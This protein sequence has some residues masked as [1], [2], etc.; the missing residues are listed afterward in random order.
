MAIQDVTHF[1]AVD[2][3]ADPAFFLNFLEEVNKLPCTAAWK[4]VILD[5]LRLQ[6]GANVLD[7]GCGMG[8]D[9]FDLAARVGPGGHV[10]GVDFSES[11]IAEADR[12]GAGRNLPVTF[13]VG[14]AQALRFPDSFFDA[15]RTERMLMHVPDPDKALSEMARVLRPGGRMAVH[16]FDWE[17]QFCDSPHKETTRKIALS[18]C[19]GMK[20]GWIGRRLP[21]LFRE[22][23]MTDVSVSLQAITVSYDFLQLLLGG[24][25]A[26]AVSAGVLSEPEADRWWTHLAQAN[27]DGNFLY[28][29][30]AFVI[31]GLKG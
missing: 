8:A 2:H 12:R 24:H 10:T 23:G 17:T 19:D 30:T 31:S 6:P 13:E 5:G 27:A 14:D 26:R 15:V 11:L 4:P 7:I 20:N 29:F 1:T 16:D 9:A 28:G 21:R 18:F 3:T 22:N 25:V